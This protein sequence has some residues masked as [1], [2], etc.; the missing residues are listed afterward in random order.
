ME[1]LAYTCPWTLPWCLCHYLGAPVYCLGA[2]CHCLGAPGHCLNALFIASVPLANALVP[3][4]IALMPLVIGELNVQHYEF[5][6][7]NSG[8]APNSFNKIYL[9]FV[10]LILFIAHSDWTTKGISLNADPATEELPSI[11][12]FHQ[13]F[14]VVFLDPS[15]SLNLC[16][17]MNKA[18]F[19][20]VKQI[21]QTIRFKTGSLII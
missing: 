20:Q 16:A 7:K 2:P 6:E 19:K 21:P 9:L 3:L 5:G 14:D 15:G 17:N 18:T 1:A 11:A 12:D 13:C 8:M 4:V 10:V